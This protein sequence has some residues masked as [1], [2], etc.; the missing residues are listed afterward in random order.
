MAIDMI[1]YLNAR[2]MGIKEYS[3]Y[4]SQGRNGYL[5]F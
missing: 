4:V 3:H 2:K 5:P 1:E